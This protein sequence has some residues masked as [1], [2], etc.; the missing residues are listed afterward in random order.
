MQ[1]EQELT[2]KTELKTYAGIGLNRVHE[3]LLNSEASS[4]PNCLRN[5]FKHLSFL[6]FLLFWFCIDPVEERAGG[7]EALSPSGSW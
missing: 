1:F 4:P 5:S 3:S 6:S 7:E 2:E